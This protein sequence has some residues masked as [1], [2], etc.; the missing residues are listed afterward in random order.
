MWKPASCGQELLSADV[1]YWRIADNDLTA[2]GFKPTITLVFY[3]VAIVHVT[4]ACLSAL[5][6]LSRNV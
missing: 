4:A 5:S 6:H 3:L 1:S 2:F